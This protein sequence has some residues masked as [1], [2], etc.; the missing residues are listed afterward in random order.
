MKTLKTLGMLWMVL[1]ALL[2]GGLGA[3]CSSPV[4]TPRSTSVVVSSFSYW[5]GGWRFAADRAELSEAQLQALD[6]L[7]PLLAPS[8]TCPEDIL[9]AGVTVFEG[10]QGHRYAVNELD[11]RCTTGDAL[12]DGFLQ[13]ASYAPLAASLGCRSARSWQNAFGHLD[14][15]AGCRHGVF[16]ERAGSTLDV[17]LGQGLEGGP[18]VMELDDCFD[19]ISLSLLGPDGG[20]LAT[21]TSVPGERCAR[22]VHPLRGSAGVVSEADAGTETGMGPGLHVLRIEKPATRSAGDF[23]LRYAAQ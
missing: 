4:W 7:A 10:A 14:P 13:Y 21:D 15:S 18:F 17:E 9:E 20:L 12:P 5:T 1:G 8:A 22:I 23:F 6:G 11:A 16:A 19:A 3:S 2:W